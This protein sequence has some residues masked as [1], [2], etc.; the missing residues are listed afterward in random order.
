MTKGETI[1]KEPS[2]PAAQLRLRE[3]ETNHP[4]EACLNYYT[5]NYEQNKEHILRH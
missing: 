3:P 5:E 4:A 1:W 2:D